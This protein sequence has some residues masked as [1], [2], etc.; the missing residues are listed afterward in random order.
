MGP[1][2]TELGDLVVLEQM[3]LNH[4][5]LT[6]PIP[7]TL[8]RLS[9][10]NKLRLES[11]KLTG[12]IPAE[13]GKLARLQYVNL[14]YNG[15]GNRLAGDIPIKAFANMPHLAWLSM[16]DN[17]GLTGA[18]SGNPTSFP[19]S[20][21][22]TAACSYP[23][24]RP[25]GVATCAHDNPPLLRMVTLMA[26]TTMLVAWCHCNEANRCPPRNNATYLLV[27][28][29]TGCTTPVGEANISSDLTTK[30]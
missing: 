9:N 7:P 17:P 22:S 11:N 13:L 29:C 28:Q 24:I 15:V 27:K 30:K 10:L 20:S 8:G 16:T 25:A 4:N 2:P 12:V 1:I 14:G 5:Q 6:G 23:R 18:L 26:R 21:D 19:P 3:Y